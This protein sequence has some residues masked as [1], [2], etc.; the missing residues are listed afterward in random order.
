MATTRHRSAFGHR[1]RAELDRQGLSIRALSRRL[2]P[3][4]PDQARRSLI[5]WLSGQT[6][7]RPAT[8]QMIADA[9][10]VSVQVFADDEEDEEE[11]DLDAELMA[12]IKFYVRRTVERELAKER[13]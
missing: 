7:P 4:N 5:R 9:L 2:E 8:R 13:Q 1:L 3:Q 11:A 6:N 12:A 10:G